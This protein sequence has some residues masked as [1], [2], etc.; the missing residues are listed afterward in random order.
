M[1]PKAVVGRVSLYLRQL[2]AFERQGCSTVSSD[3]LGSA[4]GIKNAQVRKDLAFFGQFGHPGVGYR[5]EEMIPALRHILGIDRDW[6]LAIIGLGNLGRALVRYRG[7]R[8]RGFHVVALFDNDARKIGQTYDGLTVEP[9]DALRK[10][11]SA[12]G[13]TLGVLSVPAEAAQRVADQMVASGI[14]GI[15]NFAPLT[16]NLPPTVN[17]VGVDLSLQLEH[18]AYKVR[19]SNGEDVSRVG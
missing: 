4:L 2:E 3:R 13:I 15:L 8:T 16:L 18:L 14:L 19:T 7:F 10:T 11:V 17:V 12:R 9:I 6:P 1:A 5:I